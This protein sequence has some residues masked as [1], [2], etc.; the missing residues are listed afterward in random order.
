MT[1]KSFHSLIVAP[2][3][4]PVCLPLTVLRKVSFHT[5]RH[6]VMIQTPLVKSATE[7]LKNGRGQRGWCSR[8]TPSHCLPH[9]VQTPTTPF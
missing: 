4:K 7:Q 2:G 9:L 3:D 6:D 1:P 8:L 5:W